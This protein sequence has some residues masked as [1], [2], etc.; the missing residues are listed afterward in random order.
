MAARTSNGTGGGL[1][2]VVGTWAGGVV[3][4]DG[5]SV[6]IAGG[7]TI[8]TYFCPEVIGNILRAQGLG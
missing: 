2:P 7:N 6:T 5:D 8:D 1:W 3:P 4:E